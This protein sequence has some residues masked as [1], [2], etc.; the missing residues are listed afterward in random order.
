MRSDN[1]WNLD[2]PQQAEESEIIHKHLRDYVLRSFRSRSDS[3]EMKREFPIVEKAVGHVQTDSNSHKPYCGYSLESILSGGDLVNVWDVE[4]GW[5][6][7]ATDA[8][9]D[10]YNVYIN[11][12][13]TDDGDKY[14]WISFW[15]LIFPDNIG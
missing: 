11:C 14:G 13:D 4:D 1:D 15:N 5:H 12:Y 8:V 6:V 10:S 2:N 3:G 9:Y 7:T